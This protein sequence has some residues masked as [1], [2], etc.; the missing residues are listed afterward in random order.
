MRP[1]LSGLLATFAIASSLFVVP[2]G[3]EDAGGVLAADGGG[4]LRVGLVL[5]PAGVDEPFQHVAFV[6]LERAA[7]ELG[8]QGRVLT[9]SP[10]EGYVPSLSLLARQR[11]DLVIAIGLLQTSAVDTVARKFPRTRFALLDVPHEALAH[12]PKN[13]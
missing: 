2:G 3:L 8:V 1:S 4:R 9:P 5:E 6:G 13:V 12:R 7:R 11:Y 10:R